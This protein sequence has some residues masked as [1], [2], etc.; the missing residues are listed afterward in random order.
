[1]YCGEIAWLYN[2]CGVLSLAQG[3]LNDAGALFSEAIRALNPIERRGTPAALTTAVRL[4]RA[5]VDIERGNLR[6]ASASLQNIILQEDEHRAVRWIAYG[7]QGLI[8]HIRGDLNA[9]RTQYNRATAALANM[10]RYRAASIFSRHCADL[11][12][13]L[14]GE[15]EIKEGLRLVNESVNWAAAGSHADVQ[16]QARL[17]RVQIIAA[18]Q[19]PA[20][21]AGLR[22]EL[23]VIEEYARVMGMPRLHVDVAYVD[24]YFRLKLGDRA[25]AMKVVTRGLAIANECDLVLRKISGMLLAAG[26]SKDMGMHEGAKTLAETAKTMATTSEFSTAQEHAQTLLASM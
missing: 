18:Q 1:M 3:R 8:A 9:A 12:R 20:A 24:A 21:F 23:F 22:K 15:E 25:M 26:I 19:G 4:N 17:S 13:R 11:H 2:E 14:G 5:L 10:K 6:K 7:Y 16:H